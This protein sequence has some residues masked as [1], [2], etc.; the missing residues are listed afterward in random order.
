VRGF[1]TS[2]PAVLDAT[3][4]KYYPETV[5]EFFFFFVFFF[6]WRS[7]SRAGEKDVRKRR[8]SAQLSAK[9]VMQ[10]RGSQT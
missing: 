9:R 10:S 5:V 2:A 3:G 8:E 6:F 4:I 7:D 1:L